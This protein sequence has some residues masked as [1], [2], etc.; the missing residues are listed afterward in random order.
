MGKLKDLP[1][2]PEM[3]ENLRKFHSVQDLMPG[4]KIVSS[5]FHLRCRLIPALQLVIHNLDSIEQIHVSRE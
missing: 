1:Q 5:A 3:V 4:V 2:L